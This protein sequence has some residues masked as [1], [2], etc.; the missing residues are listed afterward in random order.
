MVRVF[1]SHSS[2]DASLAEAI[3][4]LLRTALRL[5]SAEIRCTSV[6]GYRLPGGSDTDEHLR[7][8]IVSVPVLVGLVS[9]TS[10][11]SAYVLFELGARWGVQR[12]L[13]PLLAPGTTAASLRGPLVGLNA[14]A[15]S[16]A[17]QLHQFVADV[18]RLL[19]EAAEPPASI[20]KQ[21]D[22]ITRT[23]PPVPPASPARSPVSSAKVESSDREHVPSE[24]LA[25]IKEEIRK[26]YPNN[27]ALQEMLEEHRVAAYLRLHPPAS[28]AAT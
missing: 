22:T 2:R 7:D 20:Q 25:A 24:V 8:E 9:E 23:P 4:D 5:S 18:G 17:A 27:F 1:I 26:R 19:G 21:I 12:P 16:S 10:V 11:A 6:D 3:A 14:L 15:C 28:G 13:I